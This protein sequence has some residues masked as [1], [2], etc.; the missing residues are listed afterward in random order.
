ML[1]S[2]ARLAGVM[3]LGAT[4]AHVS[5]LTAMMR[6]TASSIRGQWRQTLLLLLLSWRN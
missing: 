6:A 5:L 3:A 2:L 1:L 4:G